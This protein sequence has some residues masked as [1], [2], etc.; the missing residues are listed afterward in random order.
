VSSLGRAESCALSTLEA[1]LRVVH[2]LADE[3]WQP[4]A[5]AEP[6]PLT[7]DAGCCGATRTRCSAR[8]RNARSASCHMPK[9]A[10]DDC[11]LVRDLV[12]GGMDCMRINCAHDDRDVWG[13][14]S[15]GLWQD[16]LFDS[17]KPI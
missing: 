8:R 5:E 9:E 16:R 13:R 11:A 10:A 17:A 3:P 7:K 15:T 2:R 4:S 14:S 6:I 1:V 12:A